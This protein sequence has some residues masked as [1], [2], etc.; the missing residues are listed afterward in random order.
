MLVE[1][2]QLGDGQALD[3]LLRDNYDR[4]YSVCRRLTANDA[5]ASSMNDFFAS[6]TTTV[7]RRSM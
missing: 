6:T 4:I 2:A 7:R 5:D 1:R 3:Q